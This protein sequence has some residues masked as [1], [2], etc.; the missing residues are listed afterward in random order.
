[1]SNTL[2]PAKFLMSEMLKWKAIRRRRRRHFRQT[3][4]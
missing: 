3:E 2:W 1:M 4:I